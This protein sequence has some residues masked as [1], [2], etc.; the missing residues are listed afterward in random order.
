M[1]HNVIEVYCTACKRNDAPSG[2]ACT[3]C[4][5][6]ICVMCEDNTPYTCEMWDK[7]NKQ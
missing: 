2:M 1:E 3:T 6:K 4:G 7:E 5:W